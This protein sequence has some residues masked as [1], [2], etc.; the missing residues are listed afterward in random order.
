MRLDE[1]LA[2]MPEAGLRVW[3]LADNGEEGWYA[4]IHEIGKSPVGQYAYYGNGETA[5]K[6]LV[7]A[8]CAA[9]IEV[10]DE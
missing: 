1:V 7:I 2:A 9:G 8:V 10:T 6:A 3:M 4:M 5:L